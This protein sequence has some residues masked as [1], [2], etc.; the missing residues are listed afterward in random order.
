M[1]MRCG[2]ARRLLWP[3][4]GP[5]PAST[6]LANAQ[7]HLDECE[8]CRRFMADM[9][10]MRAQ[11]SRLVPPQKMPRAARERLFTALARERAMY[12][13]ERESR[14]GFRGL[15]LGFAIAILVA[16]VFGWAWTHENAVLEPELPLAAVAEDH[17]RGLHQESI[18]T[19]DLDDIRRWLAEHVPFAV[20][21]PM[22]MG[23]RIEG[24]RICF[25]DSE[26]GVVLRYSLNGRPVSYYV[27][28]D[29]QPEGAR[30]DVAAFQQE[31]QAGYSVV[32]WRGAGLAHALVS[33]LPRRRLAAL[34]RS[35]AERLATTEA[36]TVECRL[37][38]DRVKAPLRTERSPSTP[39]TAL[40]T[41]TGNL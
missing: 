21:I 10:A 2:R 24:A 37:P 26:R 15:A 32:A 19:S 12:E 39:V 1:T 30:P 5:K 4:S 11:A 27:M 8:S 31:V 13:P 9:R 34:A 7:A 28:P 6:E 3:D 23:S 17:M 14:R 35:C 33:D 41:L 38:A 16:S 20:H 40:P 36:P 22:I 25:L 18:A 29:R